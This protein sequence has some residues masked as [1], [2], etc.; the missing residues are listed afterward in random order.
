M[1]MLNLF[2]DLGN[3]IINLPLHRAYTNLR[4]QQSGWSNHLLSP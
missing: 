4:I 2:I 1:A 3:Q